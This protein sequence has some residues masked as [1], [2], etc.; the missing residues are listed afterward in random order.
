MA[1]VKSAHPISL[2]GSRDYLIDIKLRLMM[3]TTVY[4]LFLGSWVNV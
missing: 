4:E 3:A 1:P 2:G